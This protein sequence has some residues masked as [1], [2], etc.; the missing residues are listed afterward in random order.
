[1]R[2]QV[3]SW[4]SCGVSAFSIGVQCFSCGWYE[5]DEQWAK[6]AVVFPDTF[7]S[8]RIV[9]AYS[10]LKN[11]HPDAYEKFTGRALKPGD[12]YMRDQQT[13]QREHANSLIVVSAYDS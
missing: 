13:F 7:P 1:M 12:S 11:W 8:A 6:V 9:D 4:A 2:F 10:T 3:K 5:E